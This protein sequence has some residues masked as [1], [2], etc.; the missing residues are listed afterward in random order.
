MRR[1]LDI[2][3][4]SVA[5]L[6]RVVMAACALML[7]IVVALNGSEIITRYFFGYSSLYSAEASLVISS[8]MYF[9]GYVVLLK[10]N[11]DVTLDYFYMKFG[12]RTRRVI[13]LML[14]LGTLTFFA[15]L[16]EASL[17]YVRLTSMMEHP[18]LPIP[19]SYTTA[20]T[21]IAAIG[22]LWV[23]VYKVL[24]AVM[25]LAVPQPDDTAQPPG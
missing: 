13:D 21:L 20:P 10:R 4:A 5:I 1:L 14:A 23:A 6:D 12:L 3:G 17:R 19:Q 16:F 18:V 8:L 25:Q 22:C 15:V 2:Y 24:V 11:E 9:V 7:V